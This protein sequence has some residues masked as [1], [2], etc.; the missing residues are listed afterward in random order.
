MEKKAKY[1]A[2]TTSMIKIIRNLTGR[3]T[4]TITVCLVIYLI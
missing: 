2:I 1:K 4:S 3:K